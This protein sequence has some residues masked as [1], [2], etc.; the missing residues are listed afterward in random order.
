[1]ET[2]IGVFSSRDHAEQAVKELRERGV[3][4]ES[5]VF[6]TRSEN[7]AKTIAK[8]LG[9][10]VGGFVG[11]AAGVTT[12][13]V[14]ATLLLPGIG[15]VFALGIGAAALLTGA[16]AGAGAGSAVG[17]AAT[18]ESDA[19]RPT[20]AEKSSEDVAFFREVLKEGRSLIVV[21]TESKE[22]ASSACAVLDRLGIG[23][24][25]RTPVK[26]Q[27]VTRQVGGVAV[28]DVS[29]RITLG[30]GNVILREI[31]RDLVGK[32]AKAIVL[33]LGEVQYI[34][35]SGVGE[36]VKAHTTIRN[37][38][39]QLKLT[40]LNKRVHELLE[41]TRLSAVFDIQKDETSAIKSFGG[42]SQEAA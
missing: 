21:R 26:M 19:P 32:G 15:T 9:A 22:L 4:E 27:A 5:V 39:G 38:G 14:A 1:M 13:V 17:S 31:V 25:E 37:L 10:F 20:A 29:G 36:L 3:P 28:V 33:N 12:G 11:G 8:E 24:Q 16:G 6:L 40:N 34:D 7:E 41:L 2:A 30:E 35:S 42:S 23:M 18:H